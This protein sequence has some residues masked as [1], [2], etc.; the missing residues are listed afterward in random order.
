MKPYEFGPSYAK[1]TWVQVEDEGWGKVLS[2]RWAEE[3]WCYKIYLEDSDKY[4]EFS[5][6]DILF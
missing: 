1:G 4:S 5:E 6:E 3:S 2:I